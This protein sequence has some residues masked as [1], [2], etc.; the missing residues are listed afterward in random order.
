MDTRK[1]AAVAVA[2]TVL[3]PP[4]FLP[5]DRQMEITWREMAI[6]MRTISVPELKGLAT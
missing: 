2:C 4:S 1:K 3:K 5:N 6:A